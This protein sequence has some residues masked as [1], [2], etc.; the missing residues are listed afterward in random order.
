MASEVSTAERK[1]NMQMRG[2]CTLCEPGLP[3]VEQE[4]LE[5]AAMEGWSSCD[6][7]VIQQLRWRVEQELEC[8]C[9]LEGWSMC[10]IWRVLPAFFWKYAQ[11]CLL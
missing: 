10:K 7:A 11:A 1:H 6:P 8:V 3:L 5:G 4:L 9:A 2:W